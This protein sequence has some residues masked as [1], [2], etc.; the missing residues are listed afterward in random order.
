[1][2]AVMERLGSEGRT[3]LLATLLADLLVIAGYVALLLCGV[4]WSEDVVH[5]PLSG[6]AVAA[7]WAAGALDAVE[8]IALVVV[9]TRWRDYAVLTGTPLSDA[10]RT[11]AGRSRRP[12][13]V[14][15]IATDLKWVLL[16]SVV[17]WLLVVSVVA[18]SP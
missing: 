1:M 18:L 11:A 10:R 16:A 12:A 5:S 13:L 17:L 3:R 4:A 6:A 7:V 2:V 15:R 8:N 14:A 9:L